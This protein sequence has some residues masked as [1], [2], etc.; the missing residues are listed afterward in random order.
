MRSNKPTFQ[1]AELG[2]MTGLFDARSLPHE[3]PYSSFRWIEGAAATAKGKACRRP[4]YEKLLSEQNPYNN[5]D[6]HDQLTESFRQPVS[7]LFEAHST[8]GVS[9]MVAATQ[10]RIYALNSSTGN[11]RT[12][13]DNLGGDALSACSDRVWQAAQVEDILI[14]TNGFD[15]PIYW[16]FDGAPD[17]TNQSVAEIPDLATLNITKAQVVASWKGVMFIAN[18]VADGVRVPY[19]ILW[20]D[21]RRPLSYLPSSASVA[22]FHDLGYGEDVLA[23]MPLADSLLIYTTHSIWEVQVTGGA[24]VFSFRQRYSE[25]LTGAGCLAY[26]RTLLS[27]G[28]THMYFGRDGIYVYDMYSPKP[29]RVDWIHRASSI[30]FDELEDSLCGLHVAGWNSNKKEAWFSWAKKGD[31]KRCPYR[32]LI[33]N[34]DFQFCDVIQKGFSAFS[35]Y[36]PTSSSSIRDFILKYCVCTIPEL[37]D[38]NEDFPDEGGFC[39]TP[40][41]PACPV[42][43]ASIFSLTPYFYQSFE[44]ED[45]TGSADSDSLCA[46]LGDITLDQ[47]CSEE[48]ATLACTAAQRF[49]MASTEDLCLKQYDGIYAYEVCTDFSVCGKYSLVGYDTI[50]RSG[51]IDLKAPSM[52]KLIRKFLVNYIA[53]FQ[54]IPTNLTARIGFSRQPSD[55]N[56][57]DSCPILWTNLS[58]KPLA[59]ASPISE[60]Q[61]LAANTKPNLAMEWPLWTGGIYFF[62]EIKVSGTGGA[63]CFSSVQIELATKPGSV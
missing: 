57:T 50:F 29:T 23:F 22:G 34:T 61:H 38:N 16:P 53:E 21:F 12:L 32:T 17:D 37:S 58:P 59:C 45:F 46:L 3:I 13:S 36:T 47:I 20:S 15:K 48:V 41:A 8:T 28:D 18:L 30:I 11:W 2:P 14:F 33:V 42:P 31:E 52:Q 9:R 7:L 6:L 40:T 19:R 44:T 43:A 4:G 49:V 63:A 27:T 39:K 5:Q 24:D 51:P 1:T 10:N 62:W 25:P 56:L 35:N 26:K 54:T 60:A 55:P